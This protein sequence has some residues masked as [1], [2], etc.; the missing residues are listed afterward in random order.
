ML[1]GDGWYMARASKPWQLAWRRGVWRGRES[2]LKLGLEAVAR[3]RGISGV[4]AYRPAVS[5]VPLRR[6]LPIGAEQGD[7]DILW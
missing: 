6:H 3:M 7:D 2:R 1:A 4:V 5:R